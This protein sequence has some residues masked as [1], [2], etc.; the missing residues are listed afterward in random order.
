MGTHLRRLASGFQGQVAEGHTEHVRNVAQIRV[1]GE[2]DGDVAVQLTCGGVGAPMEE[3]CIF[4]GPSSQAGCNVTHH[5][6]VNWCEATLQA[7]QLLEQNIWELIRET[8]PIQSHDSRQLCD[9]VPVLEHAPALCLMRRSYRQWSN[10]DT[11][12]ASRLRLL[13]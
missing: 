3:W 11:S 1:V 8:K 6:T 2:D 5:A 4:V 12:R 9:T 13:R 7:D 10:L